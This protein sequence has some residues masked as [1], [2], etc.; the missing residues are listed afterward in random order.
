MISIDQLRVIVS[1]DSIIAEGKTV[2]FIAMAT[3]IST[4]DNNFIYQWRKRDGSSLPDKVLRVNE[5]D[6][7]IPNVVESV[8]GLYY[9]IVTNEWNRTVESDNVKLT[10]FGTYVKLMCQLLL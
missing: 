2:Q 8:D 4:I 10:V 1:N 9:C 7:I 6:L 5:S 3:G